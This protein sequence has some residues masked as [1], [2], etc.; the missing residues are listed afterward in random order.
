MIFVGMARSL[1]KSGDPFGYSETLL[2]NIRQGWKGLP[3]THTLVYYKHLLIT[4]VKSFTLTKL[5]YQ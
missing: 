5:K 3:V 4:S 1:L 2:T